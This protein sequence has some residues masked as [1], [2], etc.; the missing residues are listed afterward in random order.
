MA[1]G[2]VATGEKDNKGFDEATSVMTDSS[3]IRGI[4]SWF[5]AVHLLNGAMHRI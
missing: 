1:G 2:K 5:I 3:A 4:F